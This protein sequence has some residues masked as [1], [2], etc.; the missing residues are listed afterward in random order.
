MYVYIYICKRLN[1]MPSTY[2][3]LNK[4]GSFFHIP[5]SDSHR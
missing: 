1:N 5:F 4:F 3:V 2:K